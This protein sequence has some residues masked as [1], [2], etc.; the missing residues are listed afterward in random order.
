M[1]A[2]MRE[3][4]ARC[5]TL[6]EDTLGAGEVAAGDHQIPE[7]FVRENIVFEGWERDTCRTNPEKSAIY[8]CMHFSNFEFLPFMLYFKY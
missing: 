2:Q 8:C 7:E 4:A 3:T 5:D 6:V 1:I